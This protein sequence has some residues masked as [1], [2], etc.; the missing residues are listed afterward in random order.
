MKKRVEKIKYICMM[1]LCVGVTFGCVSDQDTNLSLETST[2]IFVDQSEIVQTSNQE[3]EQ[4]SSMQEESREETTQ[5][6]YSSERQMEQNE[7]IFYEEMEKQG[8]DQQTAKEYF[9]TLIEDN[10]FQDGE[11]A[12]TGIRI[13]DID[14][15]GQKDM[16][17]MVLDAQEMPFY[18]SGGLWFYINDDTPYCF[19]EEMCS[20]YGWFDTFW[21]DI[22][23]DENVEIVFSAQGTGCGAVGDSYKAIFKYRN[24]LTDN[25]KKHNIERMQL[26]SDFDEDYDCGIKIEV[27]Q[28]PEKN[29]YSAFCPYFDETIS[30]QAENMG[31]D[32]PNTAR[33][34]GSEVRGFYNLCATEYNGKMVLQA[35]EYLNGEGG[36]V[37]NVATA[38]FLITWKED[39]T[40]EIIKWWIEEDKNIS[41]S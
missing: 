30:F 22:D 20:Y 32:L 11:M 41:D 26:P 13:D 35:S 3:E 8:I 2:N 31:E 1:L 7:K 38:Q 15:N 10:L 5:E 6:V 36:N 17:V 16:L 28:E 9:Q 18:G 24:S 33:C 39:G 12:L 29:Q 37:H 21:E 25:S 14:K 27:F 34:V 23:N 19:S 4:E 40:P